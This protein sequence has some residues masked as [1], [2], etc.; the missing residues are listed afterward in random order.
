M[1]EKYLIHAKKICRTM[2]QKISINFKIWKK[3]LFHKFF[4]TLLNIIYYNVKSNVNF[5]LI[6]LES[7][8]LGCSK[9]IYCKITFYQRI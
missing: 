6:L 2:F 9:K 1:K 8:I 3:K 4:I 7:K 5:I